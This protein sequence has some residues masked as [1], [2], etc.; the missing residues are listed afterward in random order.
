M[1]ILV[2]GAAG[3]I[4]FHL[5]GALL[6]AGHG[7]TGLDNLNDYY[8]VRLKEDRLALLREH[9]RFRFVRLDLADARGMEKLFAEGGFTHVVNLAAQAGV[10]YSLQNPAAY[11]SSNLTGF[12]NLLECCRRYPPEH[13]IFASS[14]SVYGLNT[15][16]PYS[17][18]QGAD[19]PVSLYAASKRANELMAHAYSHLFGIRATGLRFFTV[20]GPW[21]RPDMALHLFAEA[22]C[23]GEPIKLFNAGHMRRD[24]TFVDDIV[25][26]MLRLLPLPPE[27]DPRWDAALADPGTSSA[28][29]RIVNIGNDSPVELADFIATLEKV[30]GRRART[31]DL[32]MQAGDVLSTWADIDDLE[33]LVQFRPRTGLEEGM[34]KFWDWFRDYYRIS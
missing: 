26:G 13:L 6:K 27:P 14:S 32:P 12:G 2:T 31:V 5:A 22:I 21:G 9:P 4:G 8:S 11:V 28:P 1:Q 29:W 15:R 25:D 24:F 10:R 34:R 33:R 18:H 3:F 23:R 30:M 7:V 19:H 16:Q 20:Y 17:P